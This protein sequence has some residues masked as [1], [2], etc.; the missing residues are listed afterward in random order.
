MV[1]R[2]RL[3][4]RPPEQRRSLCKEPSAAP[5]PPA[6]G[7]H[8]RQWHWRTTAEPCVPAGG[9]QRSNHRR[10]RL[11]VP[12]GRF[13][14]IPLPEGPSSGSQCPLPPTPQ[15]QGCREVLGWKKGLE[16]GNVALSTW[17]SPSS[18]I[19]HVPAKRC[20]QCHA[21]PALL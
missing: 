14:R 11:Q 20:K 12:E 13:C 17:L 8:P 3:D 2:L 10:P 15:W 4:G 1:N 16:D 19:L 7:S 6:A 9:W 21:A 18:M 5:A